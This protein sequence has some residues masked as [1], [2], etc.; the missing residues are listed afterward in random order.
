[1]QKKK[2]KN[3]CS[4]FPIELSLLFNCSYVKFLSL[5]CIY[6]QILFIMEYIYIYIKSFHNLFLIHITIYGI[7]VW[8]TIFKG[9]KSYKLY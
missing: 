3:T 8:F 4:N 5:Y 9:H 6:L 1:M 7:D 2:K